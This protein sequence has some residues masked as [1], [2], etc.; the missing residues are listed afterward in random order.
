MTSV[1]PGDR[2]KLPVTFPLKPTTA[3]E[4][5]AMNDRLV[6]AIA[7]HLPGAAQFTADAGVVPGLGR[8][9]TTAAVEEVLAEF[10][11]S[12]AAALVQ[13]AGTGSLRAAFAAGPWRDG[14]AVWAHD[15]PDYSTTANTF[16]EAGVEPRRV[17]ANDITSL[18]R[19]LY[20]PEGPRW[21]HLQHSRQVLTDSY[22]LAAVIDVA[23][24]CGVRTIIDDNYA[25]IRCPKIGIQLGADVSAFSLFKLHGPE[26]IGVVL[27]RH[28]IVDTV[29]RANYSGGGQVQGHP[30]L[31]AL[32]A[33]VMVP[34][35]YAYQAEV[36]G[37]VHNRLADGEVPGIVDA[38]IANVQDRCVIALL[39]RPEAQHLPG[40][41]AK[42]GA[43]AYPV[44][45][46]SRYEMTPLVYRLSKAALAGQPE[47]A[48]WAVRINPM[49]A[50][51]DLVIDI[52]AKALSSLSGK[53]L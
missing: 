52:L 40:A 36:A 20:D 4:A 35:N 15:A 51:A 27:G 43:I 32:R 11:D 13:G 29:R 28:D 41:A 45:S 37:E 23:R 19:S 50:G 47:L 25:A 42:F 18:R 8:P 10:F 7:H 14:R 49:R 31:E 44:G 38:R 22:D 6:A 39:D 21:L 2:P 16:A 33:L 53:G 48:D 5:Q 3:D 26:G 9:R 12:E 34:L 17:D 24:E 1:S 46:N 30:A